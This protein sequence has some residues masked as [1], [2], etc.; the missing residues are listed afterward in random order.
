V[1]ECI[2]KVIMFG[3]AEAYIY[4]YVYHRR[5]VDGRIIDDSDRRLCFTRY[6]SIDLCRKRDISCI[7]GVRVNTKFR[8]GL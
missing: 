3:K 4:M 1:A 2:L 5:G 7:F 6:C 8:H